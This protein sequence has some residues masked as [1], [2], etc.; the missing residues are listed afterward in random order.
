MGLPYEM[1]LDFWDYFGRKKPLTYNKG[2]KLYE[3]EFPYKMDLD[4]LDCFGRKKLIL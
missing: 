1:D 3:L 2:N 4:F